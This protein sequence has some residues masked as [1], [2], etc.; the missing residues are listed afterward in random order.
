MLRTS[1]KAGVSQLRPIYMMVILKLT[2][3]DWIKVDETISSKP[4]RDVDNDGRG[5]CEVTGY[6]PIFDSVH[7]SLICIVETFIYRSVTLATPWA[8]LASHARD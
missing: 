2:E 6:Q 3:G 1:M 4:H 8:S 7:L 5:K